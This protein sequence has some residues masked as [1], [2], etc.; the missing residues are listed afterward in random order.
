ML[1][2]SRKDLRLAATP[3]GLLAAV[4]AG[5]ALA[6]A[7]GTASVGDEQAEPAPGS[8]PEAGSLSFE[9]RVADPEGRAPWVVRVHRARADGAVCLAAGQLQDGRFGVDTG[10]RLLPREE[11]TA[12]CSLLSAEPF[13]VLL[14]RRSPEVGA[15]LGRTVLYGVVDSQVAKVALIDR[16]ETVTLDVSERGVFLVV[17]EGAERLPD[18]AWNLRVTY[19]DGSTD[20][21]VDG[22]GRRGTGPRA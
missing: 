8:V 3:I 1:S 14:E 18:D 4:L 19:R 21:V 6:M 9:R 13:A 7:G 20:E 15:D 17:L 16:G 11:F 10:E 22:P 12:N 2:P 5:T